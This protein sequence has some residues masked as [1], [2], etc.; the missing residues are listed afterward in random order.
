MD[1]ICLCDGKTMYMQRGF[2][3]NCKFLIAYSL[4]DGKTMYFF[5]KENFNLILFNIKSKNTKIGK[6][7]PHGIH[8]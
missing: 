6:R 7:N 5:H 3:Y 2:F 1:L 8:Y 4:C